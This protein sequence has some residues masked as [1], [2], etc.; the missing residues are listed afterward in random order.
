M[1]VFG[2]F[3]KDANKVTKLD[4]T[5]APAGWGSAFKI[6]RLINHIGGWKGQL[7]STEI[8]DEALLTLVGKTVYVLSYKQKEPKNDKYPY[9]TYQVVAA[10]QEKKGGVF[11]DGGDWLREFF[12]DQVVKG[13]VKNYAG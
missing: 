2:D 1:L 11:M 3:E 13:K 6:D 5:G 9:M 12:E 4:G 7:T 8:P 10:E